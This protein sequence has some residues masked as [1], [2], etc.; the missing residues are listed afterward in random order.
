MINIAEIKEIIFFENDG[1]IDLLT[2]AMA[3]NRFNQIIK[4]DIEISERNGNLLS[5][6]SLKLDITNFL[7]L[8]NLRKSKQEYKSDVEAYLIEMNFKLNNIL[9][10]SDCI[11]RVSKTGFW[12]FINSITADGFINLENRIRN[13]FPSFVNLTVINK[14]FG[15]DQTSWYQNIDAKHFN[16]N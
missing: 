12:I 6:I 4:R 3:P 16:G 10:S 14:E 8:D 5:M 13:T 1:E 15:Q 2:G 7:S 11:A 9:R